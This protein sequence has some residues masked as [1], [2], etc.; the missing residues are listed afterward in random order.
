MKVVLEFDTPFWNPTAEFISCT[1]LSRRDAGAGDCGYGYN[2]NLRGLLYS[3]WNL[4][5]V[6]RGCRLHAGSAVLA[7]FVLGDEACRIVAGVR[8]RVRCNA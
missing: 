2:D 5:F 6:H 8:A 4:H 3:F 1:P 7:G